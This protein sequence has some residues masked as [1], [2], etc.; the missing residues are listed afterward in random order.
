[1]T[2]KGSAQGF[3]ESMI[4]LESPVFGAA[5]IREW[6]ASREEA[7]RFSTRRIAFAELDSWSFDAVTGNLGHSSGR[8]FTIE[9]VSVS[10]DYPVRAAYH[11]PIVNQ[12]DVGILGILAKRF[13]GVLHFLMQAK[14]E[15]GNIAPLQISPT[16]QAT[17]SNYTRVHGGRYPAYLDYFLDRSRGRVIIDQLQTEQGS[18]F[19]RK[20]NRNI[21]VETIEDVP[22][23]G[24]FRWMTLGQV[25]A[26]L[27]F[28]NLVNMDTRTV[29]SSI[30]LAASPEET[31]ILDAGD[32]SRVGPFERSLVSSTLQG[33]AGLHT[34]NEIISW[35]TELKAIAEVDV[36]SVPLRGLPGWRKDEMSIF[37]EDR[38]F[39]SVIAVAVEADNREIPR[40]SQPIVRPE[41]IGVTAFVTRKIGNVLHFLVQARME[42][43]AFDMFEMAPTVQ[44]LPGSAG[45]GSFDALP[46]F[47]DL[48]ANAPPELIRYDSIQSE[49]GGRFY[50]FRNRNIIVELEPGREIELPRGYLWMT[51]GQINKFLNFNNYFNIE[52]R[53]LLSCLGLT[54]A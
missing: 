17:K 52:A 18:F 37:R 22:V 36:L 7:H 40:W 23:F 24:D 28:D 11:Q 41:A 16:V 10:T 15:A 1:M 43:G 13:G 44:H 39:F 31:A 3:L 53:G 42:P 14:M 49:E 48:V 33:D 30:P 50:H 51:L 29:I 4:A 9:G 5:D 6:L 8:F 46:P 19:L 27:A 47:F 25:K 2:R 38:G 32:D 54:G 12:P 34:N 35:F 45:T 21:I 26:M 20:R